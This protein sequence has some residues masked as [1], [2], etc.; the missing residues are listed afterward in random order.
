MSKTPRIIVAAVPLE[1]VALER[2]D[3]GTLL[4]RW[5]EVQTD[6][7][8]VASTLFMLGF[9]VVEVA[10]ATQAKPSTAWMCLRRAFDKLIKLKDGEYVPL[11]SETAMSQSLQA[12]RFEDVD[13][14][15]P[16]LMFGGA[17]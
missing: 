6:S 15:D 10:A 3:R 8:L 13:L 12:V 2:I 17:A 1:D 16:D 9:S 4:E 7:E 11:P 5:R 14:G